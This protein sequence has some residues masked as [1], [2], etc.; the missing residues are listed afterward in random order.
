MNTLRPVYIYPQA[1][2]YSTILNIS[3]L[4]KQADCPNFLLQVS[5]ADTFVYNDMTNYQC[6]LQVTWGDSINLT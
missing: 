1:K 3:S 5:V 2:V 6:S 4:L